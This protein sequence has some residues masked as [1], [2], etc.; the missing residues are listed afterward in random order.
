MTI[1]AAAASLLI[2]GV[3]LFAQTAQSQPA[4]PATDFPTTVFILLVIAYALVAFFIVGRMN[5]KISKRERESLEP[6]RNGS[7]KRAKK[8][9]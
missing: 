8:D 1:L 4:A 9:S 7:K 6:E 2:W 5:W 3:V